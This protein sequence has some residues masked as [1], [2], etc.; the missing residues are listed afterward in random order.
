MNSLGQE[1]CYRV[2]EQADDPVCND[3]VVGDIRDVEL[4]KGGRGTAKNE[5]VK[6]LKRAV[7]D[8]TAGAS[9]GRGKEVSEDGVDGGDL[10]GGSTAGKEAADNLVKIV[11]KAPGSGEAC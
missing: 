5:D 2:Q 9:G 7:F 11:D 4:N 1:L 3:P 10:A 6:V 8:L